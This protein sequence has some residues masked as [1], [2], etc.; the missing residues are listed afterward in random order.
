[1]NGALKFKN[2]S[3]NAAKRAN[4]QAK[5]CSKTTAAG[6]LRYIDNLRICCNDAD[7]LPSNQVTFF[8]K[9]GLHFTGYVNQQLLVGNYV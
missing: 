4:L 2:L 9:L 8:Y 3:L 7:G 5:N 6:C 1:M